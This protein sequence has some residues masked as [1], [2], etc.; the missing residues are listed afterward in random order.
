MSDVLKTLADLSAAATAIITILY[1][2]ALLGKGVM[3]AISIPERVRRKLYKPMFIVLPTP[4]EVAIYCVKNDNALFGSEAEWLEERRGGET[5]LYEAW[6]RKSKERIGMFYYGTYV[7]GA[8]VIGRMLALNWS[9]TD[10]KKNAATGLFSF[11]FLYLW[12][13]FFPLLNR[14]RRPKTRLSTAWPRIW[15]G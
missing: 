4:E 10:L 5:R 6:I 9:E 14:P 3:Y 15:N 7:A 2:L 1:L 13:A 11:L 12:V 8:L